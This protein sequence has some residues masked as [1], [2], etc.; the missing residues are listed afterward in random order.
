MQ[1]KPKLRTHV[2]I[3]QKFGPEPHVCYISFIW[4]LKIFSCT[5]ES[6]YPLRL[7]DSEIFRGK[8]AVWF[9][10]KVSPISPPCTVQLMM[11]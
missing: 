8:T 1:S 9:G 11:I 10:W 4:K 2:H 6:W 3:K 7:V 5:A